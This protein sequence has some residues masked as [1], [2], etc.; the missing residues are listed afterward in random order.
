MGGHLQAIID[1]MPLIPLGIVA[2]FEVMALTGVLA[3][4]IRY[5][6]DALLVDC[7]VVGCCAARVP[8]VMFRLLCAGR[9]LVLRHCTSQVH[10]V[11]G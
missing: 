10:S 3:W 8:V 5:R 6:L 2:P 11:T 9:W 7:E 1:V 4:F